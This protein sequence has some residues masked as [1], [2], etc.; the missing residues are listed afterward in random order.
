MWG[1]SISKGE[2]LQGDCIQGT[3]IQ[4]R[5]CTGKVYTVPRVQMYITSGDKVLPIAFLQQFDS[6]VTS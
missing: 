5:V 4:G 3:C 1:E 2:C 6:C